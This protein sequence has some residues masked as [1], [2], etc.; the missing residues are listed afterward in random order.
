MKEGFITRFGGGGET[1]LTGIGIALLALGVIL[2]LVLRRRYTVV[3][4]LLVG[5][6]LPGGEEFVI[7]I[8][9]FPVLRILLAFAWL[10]VLFG[11]RSSDEPFRMSPIDKSFLYYALSAAVIYCLLW[12]QS[13][14]LVNRFGFLY[15]T[16]GVYFFCR[17]TLEDTRDVIRVIKVFALICLLFA[18]AM[19]IEQHTGRNFF[20]A[21][22]GVAAITEIREGKL[23]SQGSFESSISAGIFAATLLPVFVGLL[24]QK[25][26]AKLFAFVGIVSATLMT[27]TSSSATPVSAY[28]AGILALC[29]WPIRNQ[30]KWVRRGIVAMVV[31]L[32]LVMKAPVW[33]L[34]G[35]VSIVGG[36]SGYH[37]EML[38]D[39]FIRHF[40]DWCLIGVRSTYNWG[41]FTFDQANQY[42]YVGANGGLLTFVFFIAI[43]VYCFKGLGKARRALE[44]DR[45]ARWLMWALGSCLFAHMVA[46]IGLSYFDQTL[47]QLYV[48]LAMIATATAPFWKGTAD[49]QPAR[50]ARSTPAKAQ[51]PEVAGLSARSLSGQRW[52]PSNKARGQEKY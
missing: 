24:W 37:R 18:V 3:P 1:H 7:G 13:E 27:L 47:T 51:R 33:G 25:G 9:H 26:K 39:G 14:A 31:G 44:G 16:L 52:Q 20:S 41:H 12:R 34:I 35:R 49:L 45:Q 29:F 48:L 21:L 4:L 28:G 6:L 23:R 11:R 2:I 17:W 38:V 43:L 36:N 30:M 8:F 40:F 10:R 5:L 50:E 15:N 42:V 19:V 22:G 32:H 46:F